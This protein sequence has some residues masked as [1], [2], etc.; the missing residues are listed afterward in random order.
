M[1]PQIFVNFDEPVTILDVVL[2]PKFCITD[3]PS[4]FMQMVAASSALFRYADAGN[5]D[6]RNLFLSQAGRPK[7]EAMTES[8]KSI[9]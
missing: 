6:F 1:N 9:K 3:A 4:D 5:F 2:R 7:P 8:F